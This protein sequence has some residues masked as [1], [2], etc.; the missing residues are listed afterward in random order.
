MQMDLSIFR[1]YDIRGVFNASLSVHD[2]YII[3]KAYADYAVMHGY[4]H[5]SIAVGMDA[6]A[7]SPIL[8]EY[9]IAGV[10]E[11]GFDVI[12]LGI[13]PT[14]TVYFTAI[15]EK[16]IGCIIVTASHN[17]LNYNGFKL[18]IDGN[19]I[20]DKELRQLAHMCDV[21]PK[22]HI[23]ALIYKHDI[24]NRT[25][26]IKAAYIQAITLRASINC[27]TNKLKIAWDPG[28][29]AACSIIHELVRNIKNIE[30]IIVNGKI[31]GVYTRD[32]DTSD[33]KNLSTIIECMKEN[34]CDLG[35]AFDGDADRVVILDKNGQIIGNDCIILMFA[36]DIAARNA[37][38][39]VI[40][41]VKVPPYTVAAMEKLGAEVIIVPTGHPFIKAAMKKY[42]ALFGAEMSGHFFFAEQY[43]GFDDGIFAACV[44]I[45]LFQTRTIQNM[46][47]LY[48][49]PAI[50]RHSARIP[51]AAHK[52]CIASIKEWLAKYGV[53]YVDLDGVRVE[54]KAGWWLVRESNTE[55]FIFLTIEGYVKGFVESELSIECLR[56]FLGGDVCAV[57]SQ[58]IQY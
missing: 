42:G 53:S 46:M 6:R 15:I 48:S 54:K 40:I 37:K 17:P 1:K 35:L 28:N 45:S 27:T 26:Q 2:A 31:N 52:K 55:D 3:G 4:S 12:F 56:V 16:V 41:D 20:F 36:L 9:F 30:H 5:G 10:T 24:D 29:G 47:Q 8:A 11:S 21:T 44:F 22:K 19:V 49:S 51:K 50:K 43:Y 39:K 34:N 58:N 38:F 57:K 14:P 25:D 7:S 32:P 13:V 23:Q 18:I 33:V